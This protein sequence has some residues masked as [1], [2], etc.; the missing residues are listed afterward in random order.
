MSLQDRIE[1]LIPTAWGELIATIRHR[2]PGAVIAGGCLR[3]VAFGGV[4][5]DIDVFVPAKDTT[6]CDTFLW[7][8]FGQPHNVIHAGYMGGVRSEVLEI[9]EYRIAR[10]GL[11]VQVIE[12]DYENDSTFIPA[13]LQRMDFDACQIAWDGLVLHTTAAFETALRTQ[14]WSVVNAEDAVQAT[15]S[16]KRAARF[17]ERYPHIVINTELAERQAIPGL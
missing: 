9:S 5:K 14:K 16:L 15:R 4:V 8:A 12:I 7:D 17:A 6:P 3:D 2:C 11:P 10:Y 13:I 1:S